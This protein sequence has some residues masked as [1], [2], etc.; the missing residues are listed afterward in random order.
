MSFLIIIVNIAFFSHKNKKQ[1]ALSNQLR[2]KIYFKNIKREN[3]TKN[4]KSY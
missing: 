3:P 2:T 4:K 1:A